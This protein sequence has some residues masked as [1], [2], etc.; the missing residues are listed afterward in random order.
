MFCHLPLL[1]MEVPPPMASMISEEEVVAVPLATLPSVEEE[2]PNGG[3][4]KEVGQPMQGVQA[5]QD[6]MAPQLPISQDPQ[7]K[8]TF[9]PIKT[10]SPEP[11]LSK[12]PL[13][14]A[15]PPIQTGEPPLTPY[16]NT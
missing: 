1:Q 12:E 2:A 8:Q 5:T 15:S 13:G 11:V 4:T 9:N 10:V 3:M 6:P 14:G 7:P 16:K